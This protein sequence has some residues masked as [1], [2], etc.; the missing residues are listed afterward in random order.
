MRATFFPKLGK[1]FVVVGLL[2]LS[3]LS[4]ARLPHQK[5]N[6]AENKK[7]DTKDPMDLVLEEEDPYASS[8][9]EV[10]QES[11][12]DY[13]IEQLTMLRTQNKEFEK[14]IHAL[15]AQ[16]KA[17]RAE[18]QTLKTQFQSLQVEK[19][20][21]REQRDQEV[22][23]EMS[24]AAGLQNADALLTAKDYGKAVLAY[25]SL[26]RQFGREASNGVPLYGMAR[27]WLALKEYTMAQKLLKIFVSQHM[28]PDHFPEAALY[29]AEAEIASGQATDASTRL[30]AVIRNPASEALR[31]KAIS[32]L[33]RLE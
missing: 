8:S 10:P 19:D 9:S 22:Q 31:K 7:A 4:C 27:A 5:S 1:F 23:R 16:V 20:T 17:L 30:K 33:D 18:N 32:M 2:Y 14:T 25:S 11:Q 13:L 15:R 3:G 21:T 12:D 28:R 26:D 6:V 29:L 24:Y